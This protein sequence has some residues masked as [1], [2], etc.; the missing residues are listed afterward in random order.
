MDETGTPVILVEQHVRLALG[1]AD[2]ALVLV[3]G[4]TALS[5]P[6]AELLAE[7]ERLERAYLSGTDAHSRPAVP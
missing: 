2:R 5:A 7:P 1:A 3:H 6:A 4:Q